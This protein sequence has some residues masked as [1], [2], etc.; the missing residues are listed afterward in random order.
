MT[1]QSLPNLK[2]LP[3]GGAQ[4]VVS[5]EL[6]NF[7]TQTIV[8][9]AYERA[10]YTPEIQDQFLTEYQQWIKSSQKNTIVG[11]EQFPVAAY[12]NGT[13]ESFEKFY[14]KNSRR[15]LR[16]FKGEY[17]YHM[18]AGREY[19]DHESCFLDDAAIDVNDAVVISVPFAD[20]GDVHPNMSSVIERCDQLGVPVLIDCAYFG[21][22]SGI[23]FD[24]DHISI[25]DVVFSLSKSFPVPHLRIGMRLT[26]TD[27]DDLLMVM[28]KTQY[29]NRIGAYVGLKIIQRYG[30]DYIWGRYHGAQQVLCHELGVD[31]SPTVIFGIDRNNRYP[32]Y[33]RGSI[34]NRLSLAKHLDERI[35]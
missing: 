19:F 32:E 21:L 23:T 1:K 12:S 13:T 10:L 5:N 24:L 34:S 17:M 26:R 28:N 20:T 27:D 18:V 9:S 22:C 3:Y 11:I 6:E 8:D 14:L 35:V 33:N 4:F 2:H 16:Y 30:P 31:I 25:T 7:V 29:I 15:R